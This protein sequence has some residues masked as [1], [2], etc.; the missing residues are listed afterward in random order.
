M[1][2]FLHVGMPKTGTS[3]IQETLAKARIQDPFYLLPERPNHSS[4]V[5]YL[6]EA[7]GWSQDAK[8][9][10]VKD[11]TVARRQTMY[12][13]AL[14]RSFEEAGERPVVFSAERL[15]NISRPATEATA[16]YFRQY[17]DD[18]Q[19]IGYVRPPRSWATSAL[20]QNIKG[21]H[22]P[23]F[24][25]VLIWPEYR[26]KFQKFDDIF[27]RENVHLIKF[28]KALLSGG[29]VVLDFCERIGATVGPEHHVFEN[30]TLSLESSALLYIKRKFGED[31]WMSAHTGP[32]RKAF[33]AALK[34]LGSTKLALAPSLFEPLLEANRADVDWMEERLG[35][36]LAESSAVP[37]GAIT[38]EESLFEAA[39]QAAPL[40]DQI[41][42]G[43]APARPTFASIAEA[44]DGIFDESFAASAKE[45]ATTRT[46]IA[47]RSGAAGRNLLE[48]DQHIR[49][50]AE[51]SSRRFS[52]TDTTD[53]DSDKGA[54]GALARALWRANCKAE[55]RNFENAE[56]RK[57]AY[58]S[59][60]KSVVPQAGRILRQ[61]EKQGYTLSVKQDA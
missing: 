59:E 61:L 37:E 11:E 58:K 21:L 14:A 22:R 4:A 41:R 42:P 6:F 54:R 45:R 12:R 50:P 47:K 38:G 10:S 49:P 19:I 57:A 40:L 29:D 5:R 28:D 53:N 1:K 2:A 44:L 7:R 25:D 36:S 52:M 56:E 60:R 46:R 32:A 30:D 27:G 17:R 55:G 18:I 33:I 3:S 15:S 39:L 9:K 20:Q 31:N 51:D 16:A 43:L 34:G 8:L 26:L 48:T 24:K 23:F 13:E 35:Q